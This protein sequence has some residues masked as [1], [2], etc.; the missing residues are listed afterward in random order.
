MTFE[1]MQRKATAEWEAFQNIE[2]PCIYI[3]SSTCG[4][5]S[6]AQK[7]L[8]RL[9]AEIEQ[10]NMDVRVIKVGCMGLCYLEPLIYIAKR[11]RSPICYGNVTPEIASQLV[12]DYLVNDNPRIDLALG[13]IGKGRIEGIPGLFELPVFRPQVRIALRN[14]GLINPENINHY[15]ACGGYS[16]LAGALKMTPGEVIAEVHKSGL[17][18]R[19]GAGS[20]TGAGW[21]FC[22]DAPGSEKYLICKAAGDDP[23]AYI[24]RLLLE[25]DPH[26]VLEGMLIGAYAIGAA[27]GYVCINAE[28]VLAVERLKT[29]LKQMEDYGLLGDNVLSSNF[30]FHI[31]VSEDIS[32]LEGKPTAINNME[33]L[34]N[35][36]AILQKG[37][38]W[39]A[40]YGAGESR[41]TKVFALSGKVARAGI[42]EVPLGTTLRR[43]INDIGGGIPDGK[44]IKAVLIGGPA[45]GCLPAGDL[46]LPVDYGNLTAEGA[47]MGSGGIM[48]ADNDTCVVDLAKNCLSLTRSE[49]CGKCVL[50]REGTWQLLAVLTDITEGK[51][52]PGD[53][54]L[55]MELGE[56]IKS[57]ASC[58]LGRT[59]PNPVLTTIRH[60]REEYEAHVRRKRC[61]ALV[62]KRFISFHILGDKCRGCLACMR[63]CPA[64]AIAGGDQMIHVIGQSECDKCGI[65]LD[66]CPFNAVTKAGGV[67]PVTPEEPIPVGS[68]K[69]SSR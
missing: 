18:E 33:T 29:A 28:N 32:G 44:D 2:A 48:V 12:T 67:K 24:G 64:N 39:Y 11:G 22:H 47:V 13:S 5:S 65:C 41:G 57:G 53:I 46:D 7:G 61:P 37:A 23:G 59:A 51:G 9:N 16:G 42:I 35:V 55:L 34:A 58:D 4:L 68:W 15:I 38:D 20:P 31:E 62:C 54:D 56:G 21:G 36:P 6:G 27:H 49:S 17:R 66:A 25:G 8:D 26:A 3:C 30:S 69:K 43:I 60:F 63:N 52:K 50:C 1:Q 14:C 45:G 19:G 40:G 10:R